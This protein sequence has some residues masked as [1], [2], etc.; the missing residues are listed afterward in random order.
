MRYCYWIFHDKH[1]W[2]VRELR[3]ENRTLGTITHYLSPSLNAI[4]A[5]FPSYGFRTAPA[6]MTLLHGRG[7]TAK[8]VYSMEE[9]K[10]LAIDLLTEADWMFID[11]PRLLNLA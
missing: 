2:E 4:Q 1:Y 7:G 5:S 10:Q 11:D 9:G 8:Q 3:G 6:G